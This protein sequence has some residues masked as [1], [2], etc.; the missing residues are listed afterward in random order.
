MNARLPSSTGI[1][2]VVVDRDGTLNRELPSGWVRSVD[3]WEWL[4]GS[5]EALELLANRGLQIS[6]ATNQS[7]IGRGVVSEAE[8]AAVHK[9]LQ[10]VLDERGVA[11]VGIYV[12]PHA[13]DEG[14]DCRKPEP[15]LVRRAVRDSGVESEATMLVGDDR[16]DLQAGR[17]AGAK[18][19]LVCTGKGSR[20][21][22]AVDRDTL[23]FGNLLEAARAIVGSEVASGSTES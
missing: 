17:A 6:I 14:C 5:L 2:H 12:C 18:V 11:L 19:A 16:R 3:Q 4:P 23:V 22:N 20:F 8:V 21:K 9:H 15:G 10:S 1:H 7:G 13:P